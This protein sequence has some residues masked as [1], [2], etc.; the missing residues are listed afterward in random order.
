VRAELG[1][2]GVA[3]GAARSTKLGDGA[4]MVLGVLSEKPNRDPAPPCAHAAHGLSNARSQNVQPMGNWLDTELA[5]R[6]GSRR[7]ARRSVPAARPA[8]GLVLVRLA[9]GLRASTQHISKRGMSTRR[10]IGRRMSARNASSVVAPSPWITDSPWS[11]Q[12]FTAL[13]G[14]AR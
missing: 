3:E 8:T 10:F 9:Q 4:E 2:D 7:S 14:K 13:P 12:R 1:T 6:P 5:A 11:E